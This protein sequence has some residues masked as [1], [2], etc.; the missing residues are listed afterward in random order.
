M[1]EFEF[2]FFHEVCSWGC[3]SGVWCCPFFQDGWSSV[4]CVWISRLVFQR[5]LVLFLWLRFLFLSSLVQGPAEKPDCFQNEITQRGF[6][7]LCKSCYILGDDTLLLVGGFS[8][9]G[10]IRLPPCAGYNT[11]SVKLIACFVFKLRLVFYERCAMTMFILDRYPRPKIIA[12]RVY[13]PCRMVNFF[14][15]ISVERAVSI[16]RMIGFVSRRCRID[17]EG[18]AVLCRTLLRISANQR[19]GK[20]S[21]DKIIANHWEMTAPN[22]FFWHCVTLFRFRKGYVTRH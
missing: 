5:S 12:F 11:S 17:W 4:V 1:W 19:C 10:R 18:E 6:T 21:G 3:V 2:F 8:C 9:F 13:T 20:G 14:P 15:D 7:F 22:L 16:F